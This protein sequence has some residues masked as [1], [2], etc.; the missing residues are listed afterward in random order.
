MTTKF[1]L[2]LNLPI[3]HPIYSTF[4][5]TQAAKKDNKVAIHL[6]TFRSAM[7]GGA[8]LSMLSFDNPS[9]TTGTP[10]VSYI[11]GGGLLRI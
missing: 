11:L 3:F 7:A 6:A 1:T 9:M 4:P 8:F 2:N 10:A 5:T